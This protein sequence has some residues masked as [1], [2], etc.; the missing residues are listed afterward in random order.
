VRSKQPGSSLWLRA[1]DDFRYTSA[2]LCA[3]HRLHG[4]SNMR[5]ER[6]Q[7]EMRGNASRAGGV[8]PVTRLTIVCALGLALANA[9]GG[10]S[11]SDAGRPQTSTGGLGSGVAGDA[12]TAG[13]PSGMAGSAAGSQVDASE[14]GGAS[15]SEGGNGGAPVQEEAPALGARCAAPGTLACAGH[16]QK[17]TLVCSA[18]GTWDVNQTCPSGQF[19][20]S[21]EGTDQ[22]ICKAP[23][24][25]CAAREPGEA[26]CAGSDGKDAMQC[27]ADGL[28]AQVV[29][30]CADRCVDGQCADALPCPEGIVYS[31]DP[32]CPGGPDP[33]VPACFEL[34]P[35]APRGLSPFLQISEEHRAAIA[36]P[37]VPAGGEP[38]ACDNALGALAAVAFQLPVGS[39]RYWRITYPQTWTLHWLTNTLHLPPPKDEYSCSSA[40][41]AGVSQTP[42]CAV[43]DADIE[44]RLWL[45]ANT[46]TPEAT[47]ALIEPVNARAGQCP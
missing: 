7:K 20:D 16:H 38:C 18:A 2:R 1:A 43:V 33:A 37:P 8:S 34:C 4:E 45:G 22:G 29:E 11:S 6:Q 10:T 26:L 27:D 17:L 3:G 46:P 28:S 41:P 39:T 13:N 44:G 14:E 36:L 25:D 5:V 21:A 47:A 9:C 30:H 32:K 24:S 42:G 40:W 19:C 35:N 23:D 31:C 12:A 15:G